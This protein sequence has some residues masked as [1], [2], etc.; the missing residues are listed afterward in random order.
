MRIFATKNTM[1][2]LYKHISL[3]LM[4]KVYQFALMIKMFIAAHMLWPISC[5]LHRK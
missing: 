3:M 5:L 2:T 4:A 1:R